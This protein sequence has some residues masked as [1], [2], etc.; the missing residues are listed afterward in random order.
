MATQKFDLF[1]RLR[2]PVADLASIVRGLGFT[3]NV[4][5]TKGDSHF[6]PDGAHLP[7]VRDSSCGSPARQNPR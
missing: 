5:W 7:G 4:C 6:A 1:L 2:H 3:P